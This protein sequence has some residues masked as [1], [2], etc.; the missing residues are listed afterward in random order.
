VSS[1]ARNHVS[2]SQVNEVVRVSYYGSAIGTIPEATKKQDQTMPV[3]EATKNVQDQMPPTQ[4]YV[5]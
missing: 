1:R 2:K 4:S 5:R 3:V